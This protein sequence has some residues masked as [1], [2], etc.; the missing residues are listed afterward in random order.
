MLC[1]NMCNDQMALNMIIS[2]LNCHWAVIACEKSVVE[3]TPWPRCVYN[4]DAPHLPTNAI[5]I[6]LMIQTIL[7][8]LPSG[9]TSMLCKLKN[10]SC[11][12]SWQ[13]QQSG[14]YLLLDISR[15]MIVIV[16]QAFTVDVLRKLIF[17]FAYAV[18]KLTFHLSSFWVSIV[19]EFL[20]I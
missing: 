4:M 17:S 13:P 8:H 12:E 7:S 9:Y 6:I 2:K 19:S 14:L 5:P 20:A 11:T 15:F 1:E 3:W 16:S 10:E 18:L